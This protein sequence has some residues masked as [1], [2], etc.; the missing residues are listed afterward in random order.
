MQGQEKFEFNVNDTCTVLQFGIAGPLADY[1]IE[2]RAWPFDPSRVEFWHGVQDTTYCTH[3][4]CSKNIAKFPNA[5]LF[6]LDGA[7]HE[8]GILCLD[9]ILNDLGKNEEGL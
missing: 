7:G 9:T 5:I 3:Q 6:K 4:V 8:V 1:R 2:T